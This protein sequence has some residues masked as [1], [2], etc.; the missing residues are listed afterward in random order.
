MRRVGFNKTVD[1]LRSEL[2]GNSKVA[3]DVVLLNHGYGWNVDRRDL[4][5]GTAGTTGGTFY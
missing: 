5:M 4:T 2:D 3:S 1:E